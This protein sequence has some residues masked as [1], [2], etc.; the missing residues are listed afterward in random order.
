EGFEAKSPNATLNTLNQLEYWGTNL[1]DL[2]QLPGCEPGANGFQPC[3]VNGY[4][5]GG[6]G[7][8]RTYSGQRGS[9]EL[10]S[11]HLFEGGGRH[12]LK[13]G[14]HNEMSYFDQDRYYSG[15]IGDRALV[16]L[17]PGMANGNTD[18]FNTYTFF[19]LQP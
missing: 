17:Y 3:P 4:H 12:E 19:T 6:F 13:Y 9:F 7:L 14:W 15:P 16:Q 2:E 5:T 1:W 8:V 10:K 11:T 18:S